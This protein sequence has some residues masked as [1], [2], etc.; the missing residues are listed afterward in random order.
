MTPDA[1]D[2]RRSPVTLEAAPGP[3][4]HWR[5]GKPQAPGWI[6]RLARLAGRLL[7]VAAAL[8]LWLTALVAL[9]VLAPVALVAAAWLWH[10]ARRRAAAVRAR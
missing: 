3:D 2:P 6:A 5:A 4:G 1:G 10:Q 7:T 9:V 8:L